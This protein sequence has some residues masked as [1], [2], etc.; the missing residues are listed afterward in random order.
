MKE[1]GFTL[2]KARNRRYPAQ[3]ITDA[4]CANDVG[5]LANTP[6]QAESLLHSPEKAA[7]SIEPYVNA[8]KT[9]YMCFN[10][11]PRGDISPRNG[12]SLKLVGK[13]TFLGNSILSTENDI[14]T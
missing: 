3:T 5:L 13:S 8:D 2:E 6:T 7:G 10:Q 11:N 1:N 14:N 12:G 9:E 4:D